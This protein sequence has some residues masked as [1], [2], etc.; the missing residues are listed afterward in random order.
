MT[1][2]GR[3]RRP[4]GRRT[5]YRFSDTDG[6]PTPPAPIPA[7]HQRV[8]DLT[9]PQADP[10]LVVKGRFGAGAR[11]VLDDRTSARTQITIVGRGE[12]GPVEDI[13]IILGA[14]KRGRVTIRI[15][16]NQ[17]Q[18]QIG[19]SERL[20]TE[21]KLGEG[22]RIRIGD[23]TTSSGI[24][25]NSTRG[26][27]QIGA[28]CQSGAESLVMGAVHHGVVDLSSG[29]PALAD[30]SAKVLIGDHV[31]IGTRSYIGG[32][33][34]V[35]SGSII[36]ATATVVS[37]TPK[38]CLLAGNPAKVRRHNVGWSRSHVEIDDASHAYFEAQLASGLLTASNEQPLSQEGQE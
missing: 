13:E 12:T 37:K 14:I 17:V 7:E 4:L 27:I 5:D 28:E 16:G 34:D 24:V 11:C 33:A 25:L 30:Q 36:A 3:L 35:G 2:L 15:A 18:V 6:G 8:F 10:R 31:W 38:N 1:L 20:F 29:K 19:S 22:A 32:R 21:L 26:E 23:G 9:D